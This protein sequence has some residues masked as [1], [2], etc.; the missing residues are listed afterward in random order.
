M[1]LENQEFLSQRKIDNVFNLIQATSMAALMLNCEATYSSLKQNQCID[2][3]KLS[4][5]ATANFLYNFA[6]ATA[7]IQVQIHWLSRQINNTYIHTYIHTYIYIYIYIATPPLCIQV[8]SG[9]SKMLNYK[10]C[11]YNLLYIWYI[12]INRI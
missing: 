2:E 3:R 7:K 11:G 9:L 6:Q 5:W 8:C 12:Y 4:V 10:I 1:V